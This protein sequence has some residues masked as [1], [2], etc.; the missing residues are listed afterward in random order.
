[1]YALVNKATSA[2]VRSKGCNPTPLYFI[3][4]RPSLSAIVA[5]GI[6]QFF[7]LKAN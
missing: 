5:Q 1:M 4:C 3:L 2:E 6:E 7:T